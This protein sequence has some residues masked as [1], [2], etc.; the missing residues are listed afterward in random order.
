M[1]E[2]ENESTGYGIL[3]LQLETIR[4][5]LKEHDRKFDKQEKVNEKMNRQIN[6]VVTA[7]GR[8]ELIL[9]NLKETTDEMKN[10]V[11][12]ISKTVKDE[13]KIVTDEMK[14]DIAG[15]AA[16]AGRDQKWRDVLQ[17]VIKLGLTLAAGFG[18]GKFL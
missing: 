4:E 10:D 17:D 16:Q 7:Y 13:M 2:Q 18:F 5:K 14:E 9:A 8:V 15:I 11:K 12:N 3:L 6:D 1:A